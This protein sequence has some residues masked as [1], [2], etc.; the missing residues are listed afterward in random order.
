M[1]RLVMTKFHKVRPPG[2][3]VDSRVI[4]DALP[5]NLRRKICRR[6]V[7]R[8]VAEKGYKPEPK[9][10]KNDPDKQLKKRRLAFVAA[11]EHRTEANWCGFV[12]AC[13]DAHEHRFYPRSLKGRFN[14]YKA[15]WTYMTKAEKYKPAFVRPARWFKGK[16]WKKTRAFR[17]LGF[18]TSN[19]KSFACPAPNWTSEG[20]AG[21]IRKKVA[22]FL[23]RSFPGR[24]TFQILLDSEGLM[25]APPA[26]AALREC[27]ISVL[28]NWPKYSAELNPQENCWSWVEKQRLPKVEK[29]TDTFK[30]SRS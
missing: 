28:P 19:G 21:L 12:H 6:T 1:L 18:T 16:D 13:G 5:A 26:R 24:R 23:R 29:T 3:G 27:G 25:H 22:P 20:F 8:R 11:H 7:R 10:S 2:H 17:V 15:T 9:V 30:Q 14:R 4:H